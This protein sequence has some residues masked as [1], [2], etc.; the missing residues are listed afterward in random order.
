MRL[1]DPTAG[2]PPTVRLRGS[3]QI[4]QI[5]EDTSRDERFHTLS[6]PGCRTRVQLR[7]D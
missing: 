1:V 4:L 3:A 7:S 6:A 5:Y 2:V